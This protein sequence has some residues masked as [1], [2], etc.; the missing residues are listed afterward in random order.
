[1]IGQYVF[2]NVVHRP[3]RTVVS[4]I[5]V[6]VQVTLVIIVVGLTSGMMQDAG[7]RLEGIG[8]DI[9]L[10]PPS[11]SVFIAFSGAPMPIKLGDKLREIKY[12][13]SYTPVVLVFN[14]SGG[15]DMLYGIDPDSFRA[16]SGGFVFLSGHDMQG[17][18]DIL[19]DDVV[20]RSK[21]LTAGSTFHMLDHDFN[22]AGIVE[23]GKG[24]RIFAQIST[25]QDL[26]GEHDK[27]SVFFIKCTNPD[28]TAAVM[29]QMHEIFRGYQ[30]RPLKDYLS[31]MTQ[32]SLPGLN[33]FV[34]GMIVLSVAI[35]FLV[36]FL[37]MY[38]TVIERTRDIGI[39]KSIG[40]SKAYI[41]KAL[42]GETLLISGAGIA[43]GIILSYV[44]R[45]GF[46]SAF[47]TLTIII[48]VS[49]VVRAAIIAI[50]AGQLGA[51][52]PA[53]LASGKD[54]VEALAYD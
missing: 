7:K 17:P 30:V 26:T 18:Y 11:A 40:A 28:R 27:A 6:A 14:M 46:L 51:T 35:G 31:L 20:A 16:V 34:R 9:L 15:V 43:L 29:D 45:A 3:V 4:I 52:Y 48:S 19:A 53:Y 2:H 39:L 36:I 32:T 42:L 47:P 49:W 8:A 54:A 25:L 38:T 33:A 50:L 5:A 37:S 21:H 13:Q 22:V 10:Q 1:M 24:A 23:H 44:T 41:V 12:I